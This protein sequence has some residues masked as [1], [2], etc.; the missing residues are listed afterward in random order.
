MAN[1]LRAAREFTDTGSFKILCGNCQKR[2]KGDV[3]GYVVFVEFHGNFTH[4][5][6]RLMTQ[7][8]TDPRLYFGTSRISLSIYFCFVKIDIWTL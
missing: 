6:S 5:T 3:E 8:A 1:K 2:F 7:R 4:R